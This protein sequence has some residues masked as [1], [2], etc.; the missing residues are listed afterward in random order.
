M[1]KAYIIVD[2]C[3]DFVANDGKLTVGASAQAAAKAIYKRADAY[4]KEGNCVIFANDS[5][6]KD[7]EH[8]ELWP[9]HCIEGTDGAKPYGPLYTLYETYPDKIITVN[10]P[11]YN[12]FFKTDL[13]AILKKL[14]I[15]LVE[16]CGVCT[17][18]CVYQTVGG[19][20]NEGFKTRV[21]ANECATFTEH[22]N[23]F[24]KHME[25]TFKTEVVYE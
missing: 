13:A 22:H 21:Y 15:T 20:Y 4:L 3:N 18:I 5:H 6:K 25:I 16:V 23:V 24:L 9:P 1:K 17:D 7:D 2:M 8:F 14:G 12:A 11:Q 10:K 19:A